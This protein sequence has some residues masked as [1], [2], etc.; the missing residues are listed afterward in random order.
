LFTGGAFGWSAGANAAY[1]IFQAGAGHANLRL[2]EAQ[3]NAALANYQLAIQT[4]FR[5]VSDALA[6]RGTM[7]EQLSAV[8]HNQAAAADVYLIEEA[9]YKAGVDPYL[10]LLIAQRSYYAV[11]QVLVQTKLIAAQNRVT[12][13]QSLGGDSLLQTAPL[14]QVTYVSSANSAKLA[15]QCSP[16]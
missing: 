7:D 11:Q 9:R 10:S 5:E 3:R 1:T 15:S 2:T 6:R 4:A 13:Y 14:C 12:L 8:A 16:M